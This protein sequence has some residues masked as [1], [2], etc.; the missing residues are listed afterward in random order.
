MAQWLGLRNTR[1]VVSTLPIQAS[2]GVA[3]LIVPTALYEAPASRPRSSF[4][5]R[6]AAGFGSIKTKFAIQPE[7]FTESLFAPRDLLHLDELMF[8]RWPY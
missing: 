2:L 8:S 6:C 1:A 3:D 7:I 4:A 5:Q